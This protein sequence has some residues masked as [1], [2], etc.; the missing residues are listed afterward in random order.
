MARQASTKFGL[1]MGPFVTTI[2]T[3]RTI[4][5]A[6]LDLLPA[7]PATHRTTLVRVE[8]DLIVTTRH[9]ADRSDKAS[10]LTVNVTE[11]PFPILD[12]LFA[13]ATLL[14]LG[15]GCFLS[16]STHTVSVTE[17]AVGPDPS[18]LTTVST[19]SL[20]NIPTLDHLVAVIIAILGLPMM[21]Q[22]TPSTTRD[23]AVT[24]T[25]FAAPPRRDQTTSRTMALTQVWPAL[26]I[27]ASLDPA[28]LHIEAS[29]VTK[30]VTIRY[31]HIGAGRTLPSR[32]SV[33][34]TC[35]ALMLIHLWITLRIQALA[36][37]SLP[38]DVAVLVAVFVTS[39]KIRTTTGR[40]G[41]SR[42]RL[43]DGVNHGITRARSRRRPRSRARGP[44]RPAW[45]PHR[46]ASS[47]HPHSTA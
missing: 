36:D 23:G 2:E 13:V 7:T 42:S 12:G 47:P 39:S 30:N 38:Y 19:G 10:L 20:G 26:G 6:I 25:I 28:L 32:R 43:V 18:N 44:R 4:Q 45:S 22:H 9:G 3:P 8:S 34:A 29:L 5:I 21:G 16:V 37:T 27:Q 33:S 14:P 46:A 24:I 1:L 11:H 35:W 31:T 40:T 17:V 15:K 41:S